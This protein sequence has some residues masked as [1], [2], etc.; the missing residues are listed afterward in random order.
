[1]EE[2]LKKLNELK[3]AA[4]YNG[5]YVTKEQI[6]E[7]FDNLDDNQHGMIEEY[8]V[9]NHIGIDKPLEDEEYLSREDIDYLQ[10]YLD[11]LKDIDPVEDGAK[12]AF[13]MGAINKEADAKTKL[14]NAY[15]SPIVDMAKLYAGGKV[16]IADLIGEGNVALAIAID[17]LECVD[18]PEDADALI[19]K[20]IMNAMEEYAAT[21]LEESD[22]ASKAL[23]LVVKVTDKAKA[24]KE[25]YT[26]KPTIQELHDESGISI[27]K[28]KEAIDI[29][30]GCLEYIDA[31][32]EV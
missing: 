24:F 31:A 17:M 18:T 16:A 2:F 11:E 3:D 5:G 27:N 13:L 12:R 26:R 30:K 9:N 7:I 19:V 23:S 14:M 10:L 8:L 6:G 29:S 32:E 21:E 22:K 25:A 28:I 15:L 4:F 20:N 1:M